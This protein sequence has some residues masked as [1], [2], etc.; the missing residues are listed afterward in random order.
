MSFR[1]KVQDWLISGG[2]GLLPIWF[3]IARTKCD[4]SKIYI[5][6]LKCVANKYLTKTIIYH[7]SAIFVLY[8]KGTKPNDC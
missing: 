8:R 6:T 3:I 1:L 7:F 4:Y 5:K 2:I